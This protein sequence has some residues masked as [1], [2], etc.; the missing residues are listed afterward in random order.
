MVG[1]L[2]VVYADPPHRLAENLNLHW[3]RELPAPKRAWPRQMDDLGKLDFD[4]S[5]SPVAAWGKIFVP[6]NVTDS[7]T[8][9]R[10]EDGSKVWRFYADGLVRLAPAAANL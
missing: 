8:A 10:I 6:S 2:L 9:Y 5:Y 1:R 4:V 7:V 3:L